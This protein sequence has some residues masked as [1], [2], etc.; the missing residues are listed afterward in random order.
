MNKL[1]IV[2]FFVLL[3]VLS[4]FVIFQLYPRIHPMMAIRPTLDRRQ[5]QEKAQQIVDQL[6]LASEGY[7]ISVELKANRDLVRQAQQELGSERSN[8]VLQNDLPGYYWQIR[9]HKIGE[10]IFIV[11]AQS[12]EKLVTS[13]LGE[14]SLQLDMKGNLIQLNSEIPDTLARVALS[15][16]NAR[17]LTE[18]F[19]RRFSAFKD[20]QLDTLSGTG[21]SANA[22]TKDT[23]EKRMA[24]PGRTDYRFSSSTKDS[25]LND[26]IQIKA[27]L[28]GDRVSA[29][30][31]NYDVPKQYLAASLDLASQI[32]EMIAMIVFAV[33]LLVIGIKRMRAYEIGFKTAL[34]LSSFVAISFGI[35]IY[36]QIQTEFEVTIL[37]PLLIGPA[38]ILIAFAILWAVSES[39][40]REQWKDKFF[41]LDL[42][43]NGHF[44]HSKVGE[45][46]LRGV[47]LGFGL[48]AFWLVLFWVATHLANIFV[49]PIDNNKNFLSTTS[50]T[51]YL[52]IQGINN[53]TFYA[54]AFLVLV[55][56]L[57]R[58]RVSSTA[59]LIVLTA[60]FWGLANMGDVKPWFFGVMIQVAFFSLVVWAFYR[61]DFLTSLV[62]LYTFTIWF[63]GAA[64]LFQND[65]A[66][67]SGHGLVIFMSVLVLAGLAALF[68]RDL[69]T[70][71]ERITP[72]FVRHINERQRLQGELAVAREAQM[73]FLPEENPSVE[74]LE[75][76]SRC[77]PAREVGGDYYDFV[78]LSDRKLGIVIGDVSGKGTQAAFYMTLTKGFLRALARSATSPAELLIQMNDLFYENVK[79]GHFVSVLFAIF[80]LENKT[81]TLARGGH[82]PLI[83]RQASSG[84][85]EFFNQP[86]I[87]LG[88]EKGEV[89]AASMKDQ[90][91][92]F[93]SGDLL[94]FYTDG[95]TEAMNHAK[96]EFGEQR[97]MA[98]IESHSNGSA[99][100]LLNSIFD[101][102][103]KFIGRAQQQ[104]DMTLVVVRIT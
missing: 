60:V 71:L 75:I 37:I 38:L 64:L 31:V 76:A 87:A 99:A 74:G 81:V 43:I 92:P 33:L 17:A 22:G 91:I 55:T 85:V 4:G 34:V 50:P 52:A 11:G 26:P 82:N 94:V 5:I 97:L 27:A 35:K 16:E 21:S 66:L 80:D 69:G 68:T 28:S 42:L 49:F 58:M 95:F 48:L 83:V 9:W 8:E 29:F 23:D 67:P 79:R 53:N 77:L 51:L 13:M 59:L 90:V 73:S 86:G 46:L 39:V 44:F 104:D 100:H 2:L 56:S 61:F 32:A 40:G 20:F 89:F 63:T 18:E 65:Y 3:S 41:G 12:E 57:I 93:N 103:N 88:L 14:L 47:A 36:F 70:N 7:E 24:R 15:P 1:K 10:Q 45:N 6:Q 96:E 84:K 72:A 25:Y 78:Q 30:A 102:V 98:S 62:G 101:E 54:V 19:V